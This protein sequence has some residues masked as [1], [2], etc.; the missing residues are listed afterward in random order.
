MDQLLL[1]W[2]YNSMTPDVATQ[3][4]GHQNSKNLW[5]VIH[6]LFGVHSKA[7]EDFLR[8]VFQQTRKGSMKMSDY[9]CVMKTNADNLAMAGSPVSDRALVSQVLLG[10]DEST[11]RSLL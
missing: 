10:L 11:I 7:E 3:V 1:G 8:Q 9:L 5:E 4:M 2:L 6:Q